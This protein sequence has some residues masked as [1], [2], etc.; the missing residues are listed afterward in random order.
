MK[1]I[2]IQRFLSYLLAILFSAYTYAAPVYLQLGVFKSNKNAEKFQQQLK[3]ASTRPSTIKRYVKNNII[4]YALIIEGFK[5]Y[6]EAKKLSKALKDRGIN[7]MVKKLSKQQKLYEF[8]S[9]PAIEQAEVSTARQEYNQAVDNPERIMYKSFHL[10]TSPDTNTHKVFK[11]T[12]HEAILLSLRY[13]PDI[14]NTELDRITARYTLREQQNAFELQYALSA[15]SNFTWQRTIENGRLPSQNSWQINPSISKKNRWGGETTV[16]MD[17]TISNQDAS[18]QLTFSY[19]QPLLNG[20]GPTVVERDLNNKLDSEIMNKLKL[21]QAYIDKVTAVISAYR[22]LI[23][24]KN[25]LE[26]SK[27]S[28][29]DAKYTY[30]VNKKKIQA[31]ELERTGNIQQEYQVANLTVGLEEQRNSFI[32][33]K[34]AILQLIGLDPKINIEVPSDV[35]MPKLQV[36]NQEQSVRYALSHNTAY[37]NELIQYRITKRAY[38]VAQNNMLWDLSLNASHTFGSRSYNGRNFNFTS[39]DEQ[40]SNVGLKLNVPINDLSRNST[41]ISAKVSLEQARLNLLASKRQLETKV[42]NAVVNIK[43]QKKLYAMNIK[44]LELA[45]R[46]YDIENKKRQVGIASSLDVTNTQNQLIN[47]KNSLISAKISYLEGVSAL[48]QIL[49]TTLDV[50]HIKMRIA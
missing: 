24:K 17:T 21:K 29:K 34:R 43:M 28:L 18:P 41:L 27:Q 25:S 33:A 3:L 37:L 5:S 15:S 30:W 36:P 32:Q 48:E 12:M 2:G 8:F 13:S 23:V 10:P 44:Q 4:Y 45:Q 40:R 1:P 19:K 7:V 14:Q 6:D 22:N 49:A 39:G 42:I 47:A 31:G 9:L 46:S 11:M 38:K 35:K 50:W 20:A 26:T 16:S